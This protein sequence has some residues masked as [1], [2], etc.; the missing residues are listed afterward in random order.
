MGWGTGVWGGGK[1]QTLHPPVGGERKLPTGPRPDAHAQGPPLFT[2]ML[3][4]LFQPK[5][6][7]DNK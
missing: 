3:E 4:I 1:I 6:I 2:S 7:P 5:Y